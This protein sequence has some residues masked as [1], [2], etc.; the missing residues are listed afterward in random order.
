MLKSKLFVWGGA[1]FL[2]IPSLNVCNTTASSNV[3]HANGQTQNDFR[4]D[5]ISSSITPQENYL[6]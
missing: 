5:D 4:G 2:N 3:R 6:T 1:G